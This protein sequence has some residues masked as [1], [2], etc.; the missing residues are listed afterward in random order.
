MSE[1]NLATSGSISQMIFSSR[2]VDGNASLDTVYVANAFLSV[3]EATPM[4]SGEGGEGHHDVIEF[5]VGVITDTSDGKNKYT[6]FDIGNDS[7]VGMD[8]LSETPVA[9]PTLEFVPGN[10]YIFYQ[11][12]ADA[13]SH[14]FILSSSE[15][16]D[17]SDQN[18]LGTT[19]GVSID[20]VTHEGVEYVATT[21]EVPD[22]PPVGSLLEGATQIY[23]K[24]TLHSWM[25]GEANY[26]GVPINPEDF[27]A[28]DWNINPAYLTQF[29][30]DHSLDNVEPIDV[31]GDGIGDMTEAASE[32]V[33]QILSDAL[34]MELNDEDTSGMVDGTY[35]TITLEDGAIKLF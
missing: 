18:E 31:D 8:G 3:D 32:L 35:G 11:T 1:F 21:F 15:V 24:C 28:A 4:D 33:M 22:M 10:T 20:T 7:Y 34:V 19:E 6:F 9:S 26:G 16:W 12:T 14:P 29:A 2:D 13:T 17:T 25:T 27:D 30:A 5:D 23:Y